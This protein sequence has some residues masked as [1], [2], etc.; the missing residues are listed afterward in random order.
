VKFPVAPDK[1]AQLTALLQKILPGAT[2]TISLDRLEAAL[3]AAGEAVK[4]VEVK[5]NPPR[6]DHCEQAVL[7]C[8]DRRQ[9]ASCARC[10]ERNFSG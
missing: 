2:R 1:E 3:V 8:A 9:A 6:G 4:T 5:N 7:A 10:R